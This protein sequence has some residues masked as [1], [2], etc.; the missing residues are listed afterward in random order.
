MFHTWTITNLSHTARTSIWNRKGSEEKHLCQV[1]WHIWKSLCWHEKRMF[2][3]NLFIISI[4]QLIGYESP[5]FELHIILCSWN[6]SYTT[7]KTS[8]F[9]FC[10]YLPK[11][12]SY[13]GV[14]WSRHSY[15]CSRTWTIKPSLRQKKG[16]GKEICS[17]NIV[18]SSNRTGLGRHAMRTTILN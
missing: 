7:R 8:S 11:H 2:L 18:Y 3:W 17:V 4:I 9:Y 14:I 1:F 5:C 6:T 10:S 12:F 15:I 13:L 16:E